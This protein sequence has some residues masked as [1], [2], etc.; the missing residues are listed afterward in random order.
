MPVVL[1]DACVVINLAASGVPI[2]EI[3]DG[4]QVTFAIADRAAEEVLYLAPTEAGG[5]R[6]KIDISGWVTRRDLAVVTLEPEEFETFVHFAGE[7]DDG[8]AATLAVAARRGMAVA[9]DDRKAQRLA[10]AADPPIEVISTSRLLRT[11]AQAANPPS[12]HVSRVL[13]TIEERASFTPRGTDPDHQ[14]WL[15]A[16]A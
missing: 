1:L 3:A 12:M 5:D 14:W 4:N 9:T 2:R 10:G 16:R 7:A 13:R 11:W 6:E 15:D 8:E